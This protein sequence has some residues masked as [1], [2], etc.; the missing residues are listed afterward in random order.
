[1]A[2][3]FTQKWAK[4][5]FFIWVAGKLFLC[6]RN[7]SYWNDI[8]SGKIQSKA[9]FSYVRLEFNQ[10]SLIGPT[11]TI[12][13]KISIEYCVQWN[14][15][16]SA[17]RVRDFLIKQNDAEVDLVKSGGGVFEIT[18]D[19]NLAF[20]KKRMGRFPN[21]EELTDLASWFHFCLTGILPVAPK[22]MDFGMAG[23]FVDGASPGPL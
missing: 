4:F 5:W 20:S 21:D 10:I 13:M 6:F 14:Y 22:I 11:G 2:L 15:E 7:Q 16:L 18:I 8:S 17:L 9:F 23:A 3:N 1:M 19:G 12:R